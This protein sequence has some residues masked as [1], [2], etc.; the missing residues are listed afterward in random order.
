MASFWVY[1][2]FDVPARTAAEGPHAKVQSLLFAAF[3]KVRHALLESKKGVS[4]LR[5][6]T[7]EQA[8]ELLSCGRLSGRNVPGSGTP[9][10]TPCLN[11]AW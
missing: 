8:L 7:E 3:S 11:R 2:N 1:R 4:D 6:G 5:E 10:T 9:R